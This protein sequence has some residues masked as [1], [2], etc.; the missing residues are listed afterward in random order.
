M[1]A[2]IDIDVTPARD[3]KNLERLANAFEELEHLDRYYEAQRR[4]E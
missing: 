3:H 2:T 1:P 4:S